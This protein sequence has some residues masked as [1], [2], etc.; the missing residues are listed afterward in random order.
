MKK[1]TPPGYFALAVAAPTAIGTDLADQHPTCADLIELPP[2]SSPATVTVI[3]FPRLGADLQRWELFDE[4]NMIGGTPLNVKYGGQGLSSYYYRLS[5]SYPQRRMLRSWDQPAPLP[6]WLTAGGTQG[7]SPAYWGDPNHY[8]QWVGYNPTSVYFSSLVPPF[9]GVFPT[10]DPELT[11][12]TLSQA[13][14]LPSTYNNDVNA[15]FAHDAVAALLNTTN[16]NVKYGIS[17]TTVLNWASWAIGSKT[18]SIFNS[19]VEPLNS[20]PCPLP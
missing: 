4:T 10:S 18:L 7:C 9:N 1:V 8:A 5:V 17:T 12:W 16:P 20:R 2:G 15:L 6:A 14:T 11:P 3:E 19:I 13:V